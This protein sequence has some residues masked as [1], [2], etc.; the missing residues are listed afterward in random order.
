MPKAKR[1]FLVA[2]A[3][4][5]FMKVAPLYRK[6]KEYPDSF[7]PIFVHTGQHYD[8]NMSTSFLRDLG[9]PEPD[10]YLG[11][12]SGSHA[13]QTAKIMI[14]FEKALLEKKPGLVMVVGDVNSTIACALVASKLFVP[15]AHI[16]AG[17][18]S[19]DRTMPEEI[20]RVLTD[21]I[22]DYLFTTCEE[23]EENLIREGVSKD[24]I[25]FVGNLMI[26]SLIHCLPKIEASEIL[27]RFDLEPKEYVLVTLHRPSNVDDSG[28]FRGI[29]EALLEIGE[30]RK[31]I[32]PVHPRTR[33]MISEIGVGMNHGIQLTEPLE[34]FDFM[35]LQKNAGV[36]LT[37]SGGVQEETTYFR[38]PCLTLRE[39]TERPIT[40]T[41]GTNRLIGMDRR[42]ILKGMDDLN[43]TGNQ[44][45]PGIRFW[46][47][48]VS[49]RIVQILK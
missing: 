4:P 25:H 28:V 38:V 33:N 45:R 44:T 20:N 8:H 31:V 21:Q 30:R 48:K 35:A 24:R 43:G 49:E 29:L 32:F 42:D 13:V 9:L 5:N 17:L 7:D 47:E 27:S 37:D 34:Y 14:E 39:N 16:E 2:G 41:Q 10:I 15:I 11:V 46:D 1:I 19:F 18:R 12:G 36:V 3:R 22:S 40:V 6:M 26:E 23:A